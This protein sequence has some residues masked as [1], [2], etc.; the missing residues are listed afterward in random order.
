M[1]KFLWCGAIASCLLSACGDTSQAITDMNTRISSVRHDAAQKT[2]ERLKAQP[3]VL[4]EGDLQLFLSSRMIA[5]AAKLIVGFKAGLPN[6]PDVTVEVKSLTPEFSA[7]VAGLRIGLQAKKGDLTLDAV[8]LATV[9]PQPLKPARL[10][11]KVSPLQIAPG[12]SVP[13]PEVTWRDAEPLRLEIFISELAPNASWGPFKADLKGFASEFAELKINEA[14]NKLL[15]DVQIPIGNVIKIDQKA[16]RRE[17]PIK[18]GAYI[19]A[20]TTPP[21]TWAGT[22]GLKDTLILPRGIHLIGR[23]E[24]P[25]GAK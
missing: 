3:D 5:D 18:D 12:V 19:A 11:V 14:L 10:E 13:V 8:G 15:P 9:I 24:V 22:F 20:L 4:Q 16:E 1:R 17:F 21:L 2:A 6:R 23:I 7:G 25:G